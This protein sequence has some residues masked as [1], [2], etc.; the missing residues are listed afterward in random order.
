[1]NDDERRAKLARV[2]IRATG[3]LSYREMSLHELTRQC[4]TRAN[5]ERR[6]AA[7]FRH[8]AND[9]DRMTAALEAAAKEHGD[10]TAEAHPEPPILGG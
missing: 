6:K 10:P 9:C 4:L 3:E 7:R 8:S 1:M 2:L 5:D